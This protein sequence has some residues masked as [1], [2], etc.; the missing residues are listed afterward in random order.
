M[1]FAFL[2]LPDA[3][4]E[5]TEGMARIAGN[6]ARAPRLEVKNRSDRAIRYLE[7][8]WI[9]HDRGGREFLAGSVPAELNLAPGQSSKILES[10]TLKFPQRGSQP[11]NIEAMT[12]FVS[13]VEFS[14]GSVWIPSRTDLG[15]PELQRVIAPSAEEQRLVQI[16]RKKGL[17]ALV[18]SCTPS[19]KES[20][21][22]SR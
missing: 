11:L 10:A 8:G 9:L 2:Q 12:G 1:Q 16:Y 21:R 20:G 13:S 22:P 19:G 5:P 6:E 3:P 15:T 7:M 4:V 14:D 18:A 17:P